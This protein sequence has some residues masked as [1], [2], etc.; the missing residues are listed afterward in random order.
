MVMQVVL[1]VLIELLVQFLEEVILNTL[2]I[3]LELV[4]SKLL[5]LI[6]GS[7]VHLGSELVSSER[8]WL[9]QIT[10]FIFEEVQMLSLSL[11]V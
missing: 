10:V 11:V 3:L 1:A 8:G 9:F 6:L 5:A 2:V 4:E 7:I